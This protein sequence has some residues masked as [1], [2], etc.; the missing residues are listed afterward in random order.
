MSSE[1][2]LQVNNPETYRVEISFSGMTSGPRIMECRAFIVGPLTDET[3]ATLARLVLTDNAGMYGAPRSLHELVAVVALK[4]LLTYTTT[5]K[6][7]GLYHTD[8]HYVD[9]DGVRLTEREVFDAWNRAI[10]SKDMD[11]GDFNDRR[12]GTIRVTDGQ[13]GRSSGSTSGSVLRTLFK[14]VW[15]LGCRVRG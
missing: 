12:L 10:M 11:R 7:F 13:D 1:S 2:E 3:L 4:R 15:E 5:D 8:I 14:T 6:V 9:V